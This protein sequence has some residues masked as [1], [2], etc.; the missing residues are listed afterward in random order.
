[1][2]ILQPSRL[3]MISA[4]VIV[5]LAFS[6]PAIQTGHA[7]EFSNPI[8]VENANQGDWYWPLQNPATMRE[9]EG[10]ASAT[11]VNVGESINLFVSTAAPTTYS[12]IVYRMGWYGGAGARRMRVV[13]NLPGFTQPPPTLTNGRADCHWLNPYPLST[14]SWTSGVFLAKL[15]AFSGKQS[16]IIFVVRDDSRPSDYLFQ[17]SVTTYQA[18]NNWPGGAQAQSFYDVVGGRNDVSFDRPYALRQ[19]PNDGSGGGSANAKFGVGAGEFL[20]TLNAADNAIARGQEYNMVRFLEREGLDVTYSTNID[21]DLRG[22]LLLLHKAFLSVGHDEYWTMTMRL[23][24]E[25]A[26]DQ[27]TNLAFFGGNTGYYLIQ[28]QSGNRVI[29]KGPPLGLFRHPD[30]NKPEEQLLG[31]VFEAGVTTLSGL[32]APLEWPAFHSYVIP[33]TRWVFKNTGLQGGSPL[34]GVM[35]YEYDRLCDNT[36]YRT[37]DDANLSYRNA[38]DPPAGVQVV[39]YGSDPSTADPNYPL[40]EGH[41]TFYQTDKGAVVFSAGTINWSWG[42]DDYGSGDPDAQALATGGAQQLTRNVLKRMRDTDHVDVFARGYDNSIYQITREN[43]SFSSW[44][45]LGGGFAFGPTV[46]S[47]VPHELHVFGVGLD[48]SL[49]ENIWT[50]SGWSGW[51]GR[52]IPPGVA[53]M[54]APAAVGTGEGHIDVFARG[55]NS[56]MYQRSYS[57]STGWSNWF[58]L[59]GGFNQGPAVTT[60]GG[61]TLHVFGVGLDNELWDNLWDGKTWSGWQ[62]R[63]SPPGVQLTSAPAAMAQGGGY[64]DVFVR[65]AD[66]SF[67]HLSRTPAGWAAW[68]SFGDRLFGQGPAVA[69]WGTNV[70]EVFGV[71]LDNAV[72]RKLWNGQT[73]SDW[74]SMGGGLTSQPSAIARYG[75]N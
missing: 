15:T 66:N 11:S 41:A 29:Y 37:G 65:G 16:Y 19:K 27:G 61:P 3:L 28:L 22:Q 55:N 70:L 2:T 32:G 13:N 39:A 42:L 71:G 31:V 52:G 30:F 25:A 49:Y 68:Q 64:V 6:V 40:R 8:I 12:I 47:S 20:T 43:G 36:V 73:W 48:Y 56:R 1:M 14:S 59:G 33:P 67:Y 38:C 50:D 46:A 58:D 45:G 51:Q 7:T 57:P 9:I 10:F 54:S 72:W 74:S 62:Q 60:W 53:L 44:Q 35:G 63:L 4:A 23:N 34:P 18:Y 75:R 17:S 5:C 24:L 69:S 21:T 26:R